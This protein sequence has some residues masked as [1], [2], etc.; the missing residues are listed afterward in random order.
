MIPKCKHSWVESDDTD[1]RYRHGEGIVYCEY[2]G[3]SEDED[4]EEED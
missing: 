2:C 4:E 1:D 3:A